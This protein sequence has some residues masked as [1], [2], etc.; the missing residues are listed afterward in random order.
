MAE[1]G[2]AAQLRLP[3]VALDHSGWDLYK[4]SLKGK[5]KRLVPIAHACLGHCHL[6]PFVKLLFHSPSL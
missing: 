2:T 1:P 4:P 3:R 6:L 5:E